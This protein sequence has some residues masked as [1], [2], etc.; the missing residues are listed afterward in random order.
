MHACEAGARPD[1]DEFGLGN[2][3]GGVFG[4]TTMTT[5][6]GIDEAGASSTPPCPVDRQFQMLAEGI[7][8]IVWL[9]SADSAFGYQNRKW[10]EYTGLSAA[11]SSGL[12]QRAST[13]MI[14]QNPARLGAGG[15]GAHRA[16]F[17][18]GSRAATVSTA[19]SRE[20][21]SRFWPMTAS[22]PAGSRS[23]ARAGTS[24]TRRLST[25]TIWSDRNR[26]PSRLPLAELTSPR[27]RQSVHVRRSSDQGRNSHRSQP[28]RLSKPRRYLPRR[29]W[30]SPSGTPTGSIIRP[31][32]NRTF[33]RSSTG[34][35]WESRLATMSR[36]AWPAG[37]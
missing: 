19:G 21:S 32:C 26:P 14:W 23:A 15:P 24:S 16:S 4:V 30:A 34:R 17:F 6:V 3:S 18:F 13:L 1:T 9:A 22:R 2:L 7:P 25:P 5:D 29:Y 33:E 11:E 27:A 31:R 20:G 36:S 28:V 12:G 37:S 8:Q 10:C 35:T